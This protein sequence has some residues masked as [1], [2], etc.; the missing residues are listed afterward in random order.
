MKANYLLLSILLVSSCIASTTQ[1][2]KG[3]QLLSGFIAENQMNYKVIK[4]DSIY[5]LYVLS[6]RANAIDSIIRKN[7]LTIRY[8][9]TTV[10]AGRIEKQM[11]L[12]QNNLLRNS[13]TKADSNLYAFTFS[14]EVIDVNNK[15]QE[16]WIVHLNKNNEIDTIA[17]QSNEGEYE[18][19]FPAGR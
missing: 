10:E 11:L 19:I 7:N 17:M 3:S 5:P 16:S 2:E 14:A 15:N 9:D 6:N 12:Y 1:E 8:I 13:I 4:S 18:I